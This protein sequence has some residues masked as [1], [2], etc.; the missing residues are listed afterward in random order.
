LKK[1]SKF[2]DEP[3][4]SD[5]ADSRPLALVREER[6]APRSKWEALLELRVLLPYISHL[7]PLL[8][9][10]SKGSPE[11]HEL[12]RGLA[13]IQTGSRELETLA[14]NQTHQ[15]ERV[16]EQVIQLQAGHLQNVEDTRQFFTEMRSFRRWMIR[17]TLTT[18]VL[19]G[20][21]AGLVAYLLLRY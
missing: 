10:S 21:T 17:I 12:T 1:T 18:A 9:R 4:S 2:S 19:V 8:E 5:P 3:D 16:E 15:L 11:M 14:R 7:A 6:G 13:S 20:A